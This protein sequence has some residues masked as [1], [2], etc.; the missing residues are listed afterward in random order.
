MKKMTFY[1]LMILTIEAFCQKKFNPTGLA[2]SNFESFIKLQQGKDCDYYRNHE[3]FQTYELHIP[4]GEILVFNYINTFELRRALFSKILQ[5]HN[6]EKDSFLVEQL[7][8]LEPTKYSFV[9]SMLLK[10]YNTK[11]LDSLINIYVTLKGTELIHKNKGGCYSKCIIVYAERWNKYYKLLGYTTNDFESFFYEVLLPDF[12]LKP[13]NPN[14]EVQIIEK[15]RSLNIS[16]IDLIH[17][18]NYYVKLKK[19]KE[20]YPIQLSAPWY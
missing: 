6:F 16:N 8:T 4:K 15:L 19:F 2:Y 10:Y 14:Y 18:Y 9:D 1:I 11:D 12:N 13:N 3:M 7:L 17:Y 20:Q 5:K